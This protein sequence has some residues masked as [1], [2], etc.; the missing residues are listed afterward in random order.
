MV[1]LGKVIPDFRAPDSLRLGLAPLYVSYLEVH[2]GVQ[3]MREI[4]ESGIYRR[5]AGSRLTVT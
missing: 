4:V 1:E 3:R 2:T 5:F